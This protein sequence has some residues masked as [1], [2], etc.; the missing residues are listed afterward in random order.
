MMISALCELGPL[1]SKSISVI[2]LIFRNFAVPQVKSEIMISKQN[3]I[4]IL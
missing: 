2:T 4:F 3:I 1:V